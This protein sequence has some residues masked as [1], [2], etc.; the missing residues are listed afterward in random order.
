MKSTFYSE[1]IAAAKQGPRL[2]FAPLVGAINA[3]RDESARIR[4]G[5]LPTI[6]EKSSSP[7]KRRRRRL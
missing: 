5:E 7:L 4:S 6:T 2:F 3:I 1:F